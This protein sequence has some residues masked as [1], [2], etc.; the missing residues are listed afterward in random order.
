MPTNPGHRNTLIGEYAGEDLTQGSSAS[1]EGGEN[2]FIGSWAGRETTSGSYN[3]ALGVNSGRKLT[4][5]DQNTF[6]GLGAGYYVTT[7]NRNICIGHDA[8][9]PSTST[10]SNKLYIDA[11]GRNGTNSLIYG[12]QDGTQDLTL[13]ADVVISRSTTNSTGTLEVQ[14]GEG[15]AGLVSKMLQRR[16]G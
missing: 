13:N 5:G 1:D 15:R 14:G 10:L 16:L 6:L 9:P 3:T 11:N 2:T 12:D 8:G 7:G 4:T